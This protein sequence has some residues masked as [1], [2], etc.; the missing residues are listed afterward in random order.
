MSYC[1]FQERGEEVLG[2]ADQLGR[3]WCSHPP[4]DSHLLRLWLTSDGEGAV[5]SGTGKVVR[6]W[7]RERE[8][9]R[10]VFQPLVSPLN[11]HLNV[12]LARQAE[13]VISFSPSQ[14][15][16]VK[17]TVTHKLKEVHT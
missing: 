9:E 3:I 2:Y 4:P 15:H 10:T 1:V 16:H 7:G 12:Q 14:H 8:A 13:A 5:F 17:F 11:K 6:R